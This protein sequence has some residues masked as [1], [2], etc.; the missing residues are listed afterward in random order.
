[1]DNDHSIWGRVARG[2]PE[3]WPRDAQGKP[4]QPALLTNLPEGP[5][6]DLTRNMLE[7]YGIPAV[8]IYQDDGTFVRVI[9]GTSSYGVRLFV[10]ASRQEEARALLDSAPGLDSE[11]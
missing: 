10:P 11:E 8:E 9:C 2:I 1:M 5:I 6:A 4:E 3:S 7:V